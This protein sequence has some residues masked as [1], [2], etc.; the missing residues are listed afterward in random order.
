MRKL[1][2]PM[3]FWWISLFVLFISHESNFEKEKWKVDVSCNT[4]PQQSSALWRVL[5]E[6]NPI[7]DLIV[8]HDQQLHGVCDAMEQVIISLTPPPYMVVLYNTM[9]CCLKPLGKIQSLCRLTSTD[10]CL[11]QIWAGFL[12]GQWFKNKLFLIWICI[13]IHS[14]ILIQDKHVK[15]FQGFCW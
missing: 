3:A 8:F 14:Q 2:R 10:Y 1:V 15:I 6:K 5:Q 9:Y 12:A 7:S 11:W 4:T 13:F